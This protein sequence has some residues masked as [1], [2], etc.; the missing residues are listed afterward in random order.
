MFESMAVD[1]CQDD[2]NTYISKYQP[3]ESTQSWF[4]FALE[5]IYEG[6]SSDQEQ[7]KL[8]EKIHPRYAQLIREKHT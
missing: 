1:K 6:S 7:E 2:E 3:I 5:A 8:L 4:V